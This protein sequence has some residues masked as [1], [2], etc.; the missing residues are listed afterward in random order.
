MIRITEITRNGDSLSCKAFVENSEEAVTITIDPEGELIEE[1]V[2][3]KDFSWCTEHIAH[4]IKY[5]KSLWNEPSVPREKLIM[6]Y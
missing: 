2:L 6:W 3:P 5:L 4:A 1:Y